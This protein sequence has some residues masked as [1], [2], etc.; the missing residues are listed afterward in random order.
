MLKI[1]APQ[2]FKLIPWKNGKGTTTELAI[3]DGGTLEDF[4]W[5]LSI[6]SVIEN[7][8]FS[9]F[10]GYLRNL[11]LIE[12]NGIDLQHSGDKIENGT[13]TDRL[14]TPLSFAT[15]DG[16]C[17]TVGRLHDG[18]IKDL[19]LMTRSEKYQCYVDTWLDRQTRQQDLRT[20]NFVFSLSGETQL[21][22]IDNAI[23]AT[24]PTRHLACIEESEG[25]QLSISGENLVYIGLNELP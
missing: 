20:L 10:S 19:N 24:F 8:E 25:S 14:T 5:R 3:S 17:R 4:D 22:S 1:I 11:I 9:D 6:A 23:D 15:F 7:G 21:S 13:V 18:P 12:G 2:S 16:G